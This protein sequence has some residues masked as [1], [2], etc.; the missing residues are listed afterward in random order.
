VPRLQ[1][2]V[3]MA[4]VDARTGTLIKLGIFAFLFT[5]L[6]GAVWS[7]LLALNL[8]STPA[9]PWCVAVMAGLLWPA[10]RMLSS[11][12]KRRQM[13]RATRVSGPAFTWALIAG[14]LSIVSFTGL[15]IVLIQLVHVKG[16]VLPPFSQYPI[17]TVVLV[18]VMASFMTAVVEEASFRGYFQGALEV[19]FGAVVAVVIAALLMVPGHALTQGLALTTVV[20]Y[21]LVD[22]ML[23]AIAYLVQSIVPGIIVHTVGLIVFFAAVWPFDAHR[24]FVPD[25]GPDMWFWIHVVQMLA[26]AA[27]AL[28]AFRHLARISKPLRA[29]TLTSS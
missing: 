11:G 14:L 10:W 21:L 16:N 9:I 13:L 20:F 18:I 2:A 1:T 28:L 4:A 17:Y 24:T 26:G 19:R 12:P 8:R 22:V 7:V 3:R 29:A 25:S 5:I 27:C 15:W 6:A 23:G